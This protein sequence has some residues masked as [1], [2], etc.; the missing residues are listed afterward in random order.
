MFLTYCKW[1][2]ALQWCVL[3]CYTEL[4]WLCLS[5]FFLESLSDGSDDHQRV[6][7]L[8]TY[9]QQTRKANSY[10]LRLVCKPFRPWTPFIKHHSSNVPKENANSKCLPS[11]L[12]FSSVIRPCIIPTSN[13]VVIT[14]AAFYV[15]LFHRQGMYFLWHLIDTSLIKW[16]LS[17]SACLQE[18]SR[19]VPNKCRSTQ[20][21]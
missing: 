3:L 14:G 6:R 2:F 15:N 4:L 12:T 20:L 8:C 7:I 16:A 18:R 1:A 9:Q 19:I 21:N 5:L 13:A 10:S 11:I 17:T